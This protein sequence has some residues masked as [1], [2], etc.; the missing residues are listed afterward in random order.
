MF[1]KL[2]IISFLALLPVLFFLSG[3]SEDNPVSEQQDHFKAYGLQVTSSG[4]TVLDY[5]KGETKDT[6]KVPYNAM[7]DHYD[8][9][10]Y[11]ADKK[12]IEPPK[13]ANKKMAYIIADPTIAEIFQHEGEE[14]SYEFHIKGLQKGATTLTLKVMHNDHADFTTIALPLLVQDLAGAHGAPVG[15]IVYDEES[16]S[17]L[18]KYN[19]DGTITGS[20]VVPNGV[21]TDHMIIK[22][23]DSE[24][25]LFW[26]PVPPHALK[27]EIENTDILQYVEPPADEPWAF[28]LIGKKAGTTTIKFSIL[29]DG[30]VG[31]AF[32]QSIRVK[33]Q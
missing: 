20:F 14:G 26:P 27:I 17:Q 18:V 3:C 33:V 6:F 2:K 22:F 32:T 23:F 24:N 4:I 1:A 29:H 19:A 28:Q 13:D 11:D 10:F 31:K 7:T 9:M 25:R 16:D 30:N 21:T 5:F 15:F 12:L 8:I